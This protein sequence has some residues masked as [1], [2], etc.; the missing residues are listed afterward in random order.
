MVPLRATFPVA[1]GVRE[2]DVCPGEAA[3][4][5]LRD[6][7]LER[8]EPVI[9]FDAPQWSDALPVDDVHLGA[10]PEAQAVLSVELEPE[11]LALP[12]GY[13]VVHRTGRSGNGEMRRAS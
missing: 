3:A 4:L 13:I 11:L 5:R 10:A 12:Y 6:K 1:A 2:T 9:G 7:V 8:G